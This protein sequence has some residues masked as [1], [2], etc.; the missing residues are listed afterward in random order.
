MV[1]GELRATGP[2]LGVEIPVES[3]GDCEPVL[4]CTLVRQNRNGTQSDLQ[5]SWVVLICPN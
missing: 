1:W 3:F 2:C 5:V 4:Q